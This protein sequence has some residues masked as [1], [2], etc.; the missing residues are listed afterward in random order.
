MERE[1][2]I[3]DIQDITG[4]EK[5]KSQKSHLRLRGISIVSYQTIVFKRRATRIFEFS[6]RRRL[7][8]PSDFR[9]TRSVT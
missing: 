3:R 9:T 1:R 8:A 6:R 4:S 5:Q 7:A 2:Q